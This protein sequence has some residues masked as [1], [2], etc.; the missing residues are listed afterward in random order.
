[1]LV[2]CAAGISRSTAAAL[3]L[4]TVRK[5]P[6]KE[7][8]ALETLLEYLQKAEQKGLRDLAGFYPNIHMIR[9]ADELLE[10]KGVFL[11]TLLDYMLP[12]H[13]YYGQE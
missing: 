10:R 2:H 9:L 1:V 7:G 5:G 8:E 4:L 13:P 12:R 11:K 3:I 6:G